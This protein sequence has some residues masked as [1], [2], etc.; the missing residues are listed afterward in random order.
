M[1]STDSAATSANNPLQLFFN[2]ALASSWAT[3]VKALLEK[4][5]PVNERDAQGETMLYASVTVNVLSSVELLL[6]EKR[7]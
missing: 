3:Q 1:P 4:G 7:N 2:Q 6:D 5:T